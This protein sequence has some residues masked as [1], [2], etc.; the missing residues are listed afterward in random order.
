M[1]M[2]SAPPEQAQITYEQFCE[3]WLNDIT[4][5]LSPFE[6][7]QRF[8]FKLVTQ[9]LDVPEDDEDLV[10]CDGT[11][12]GGIDIAYLRR[13]ETSDDDQSGQSTET[14]GDTWYLIQS[15]YGS[16]FQGQET[17]ISE[18]RKVIATLSGNNDRLSEQTTHLVGMLQNFLEK[19]SEHDKL[20]LVFATSQPMSESDRK[21]LEDIRT[22]GN[23]QFPRMFDVEDISLQTIWEKGSSLQ[24]QAISLQIQGDFVQPSDG[25]KVGTVTLTN[26]YQFLKAYRD[27]TGNLD[28]LYEKNVRQ[29]LGG[30][31]KINK[32]IVQTLEK[33][34]QMFGLYNNGITIVVAGF[35]TKPDGQLLLY[36]PY[37][38]NGCQTTKTIWNVLQQKLDSGGTGVSKNT[39]SWR[40]NAERG[41]VVTK[42]VTGRDDVQS[43]ITKFTNSQNAVREQ[44]L[45]AL[46]SNFQTWKG[47][48]ASKYDIFLEIQRGGW[49]AQKAF[50]NSHPNERRFSEFANAFELLKVYGAGWLRQPGHAFGRS[51]PFLP[52]GS[53]FNEATVTAPIDGDDLYAAY[54]LQQSAARFNFG[55]GAS[56]P[57]SRRQTRFLWYFVVCDLLREVLNWRGRNSTSKGITR[58]FHALLNPDNQDIYQKLLDSG[59]EVIDQY[60]NQES[61]NSVFNEQAFEGDLNGWLKS[62]RLGKGS[63]ET[64]RLNTLIATHKFFM[65]QP[66]RGEPALRQLVDEA[67]ASG[68]N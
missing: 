45:L 1:K 4:D 39:E 65:G 56:V 44:D 38:V 15:K 37:V 12:D 61:E 51:A 42:I 13:A 43:N 54:M 21:A 19:A 2:P 14:E 58:A 48:M 64:Y 30:R 49:D 50:Q 6:K 16:A 5:D 7:G 55:R 62:D 68:A 34:P 63:D 41:V 27:K 8:A 32:G 66:F 20:I 28:Q 53:V 47:S 52:R 29:F 57:V 11:G 9:W 3:E 35:S 59:I 46:D 17:V 23:Q 18:G 10:L 24:P 25:L 22:L 67:V 33:E 26:L 31:R 60:L 36:D 40:V